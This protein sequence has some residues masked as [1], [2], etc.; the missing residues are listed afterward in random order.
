MKENRIRSSV[1]RLVD[2]RVARSLAIATLPVLATVACNDNSSFDVPPTQEVAPARPLKPSPEFE[3]LYRNM[4]ASAP[5]G[6]GAIIISV[7]FPEKDA[8]PLPDIQTVR[9]N[10]ETLERTIEKETIFFQILRSGEWV[11]S[12][13][14][15]DCND[16]YIFNIRKNGEKEISPINIFSDSYDGSHV[17]VEALG[18]NSCIGAFVYDSASKILTQ[19]KD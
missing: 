13:A 5:D 4:K 2:N 19:V 6:I 10:S 11:M 16:R 17:P 14:L 9:E 12:F 8:I 1:S 15:P 18:N 7:G 3:R